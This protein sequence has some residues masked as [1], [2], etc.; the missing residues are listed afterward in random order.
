[1]KE[2]PL[3]QGLVALVDDEDMEYLSQFTWCVGEV[4]PGRRYAM[5]RVRKPDG[6]QATVYM[7]RIIL[8]APPK[9]KVDHINGDGLDNRRENIR[10]CSHSQNLANRKGPASHNTSGYVGVILYRGKWRAAVVKD[11][12]RHYVGQFDTPE[13]AARARD[14]KARALHGPFAYVNFEEE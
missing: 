2:I 14:K 4:S 12:K 3:T 7:H 13:Q 1:M 8:D 11:N 6:K 9:K 5:T 10:L